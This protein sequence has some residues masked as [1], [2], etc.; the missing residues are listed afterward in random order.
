MKYFQEIIESLCDVKLTLAKLAFIAK[1][2]N[3]SV[4]GDDSAYSDAYS[5][6]EDGSVTVAELCT[7]IIRSMLDVEAAAFESGKHTE[8]T[9]SNVL[10]NAAHA[11]DG[12]RLPFGVSTACGVSNKVGT[13]LDAITKAGEG[14]DEKFY[15]RLTGSAYY[16]KYWNE[17]PNPKEI[18]IFLA[19]YLHKEA[20]QYKAG[21]A[22]LPPGT[23]AVPESAVMVTYYD[24]NDYGIVFTNEEEAR[25]FATQYPV[26]PSDYLR[27][28]PASKAWG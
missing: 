17:V 19:K 24:L 10:K 26:E 14:V 3:P 2:P 22:M 11:A 1:Y 6:I 13:L 8:A 23:D 15:S 18:E 9:V 27:Y 28:S 5:D 20:A 12:M 21:K 4:L 7:K 25:S 16:G